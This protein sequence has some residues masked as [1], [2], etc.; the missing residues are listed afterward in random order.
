MRTRRL[1]F[2]WSLVTGGLIALF[3]AIY[4]LFTG[5]VPTVTSIKM[6]EAWELSLPFGISRWWDVLIGPIWSII[7][8]YSLPKLKGKDDDLAV[9]LIIGVI[10]G[11]GASLIIGLGVGLAVGLAAGLAAGLGVGLAAG[12][13][14]G[15]AALIKLI[16]NQRFWGKIGNWLMVK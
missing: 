6:T 9:S 14:V 3:W 1:M 16:A 5:S 11:L 12:L 4:Y 2:R 13:G 7:V 8:I 10:T 15:L